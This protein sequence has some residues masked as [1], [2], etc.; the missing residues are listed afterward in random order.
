MVT[1][2]DGSKITQRLLAGE[3]YNSITGSIDH[4]GNFSK[5]EKLAEGVKIAAY[6]VTPDK[7]YYASA[8]LDS[9][10]LSKGYYL[11]DITS[12]Y[13]N[14]LGYLNTKSTVGC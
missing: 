9:D 14:I 1:G 7:E 4:F 3:S 11:N 10:S 12:G 6:D 8:Y 5:G 13:I 2:N